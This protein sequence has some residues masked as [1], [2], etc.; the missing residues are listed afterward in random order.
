MIR[1]WCAA[2]L[3]AVL[4]LAACRNGSGGRP[5]AGADTAP[6]DTAPADTQSG[7]RGAGDDLGGKTIAADTPSVDVS[8]AGGV[9]AAADRARDEPPTR[10]QVLV[11]FVRLV[12]LPA[13]SE[14]EHT[15]AELASA[16]ATLR[17][18]PSA[19]ALRAARA[20][21]RQARSV[22]RQTNAF[23]IGPG[24]D[25]AIT[26]GVVDEPTNADRLARLLASDTALDATAVLSLGAN[27]RGFLAIEQL[28]FTPPATDEE[29]AA[30]FV[31]PA[32]HRRAL[33]VDLLGADLSAK[34][35]S[36]AAA[37]RAR[38][39]HELESAGRGSAAFAR[40]RDAFDA[41]MNRALAIAD[42]AIDIFRQASGASV[43]VTLPIASASD[44]V[45]QDLADD[46]A[47]LEALYTCKRGATSGAAIADLVRS[48]NAP[49]DAELARTLAAAKA[50]LTAAPRPLRAGS[51]EEESSRRV[52]AALRAL[53]AAL[54][55]GVFNA[56]GISVGFSD[57]DGD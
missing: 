39:G 12:A 24:D 54:A 4:A 9:D 27:V 57:N 32:G 11:D 56:L 23:G 14:L 19:P 29:I 7:A 26:D 42:R 10:Q 35:R 36:V 8:I 30:L 13:Y 53:K 33:Y 25:L 43:R 6:A 5:R 28:L 37:W 49:A 44:A 15:G 38:Y 46:L 18:Q 21:W 1:L 2:T 20:A 17:A 48:M 47:G 3:L 16:L 52:I 31:A 41:L 51:A 22:W 34:L 45:T 55:T 50:A 40:E